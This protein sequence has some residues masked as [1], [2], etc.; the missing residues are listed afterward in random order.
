MQATI[1][2]LPVGVH[3][4]TVTATDEVGEATQDRVMVTVIEEPLVTP[5]DMVLL[6]LVWR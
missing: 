2:G 3:T 6:P 4:V 5:P 1:G